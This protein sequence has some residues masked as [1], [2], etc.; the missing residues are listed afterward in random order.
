MNLLGGSHRSRWIVSQTCSVRSS[1]IHRWRWARSFEPEAEDFLYS[2][3]TA[4]NDSR[5]AT[6]R[7]FGI[8]QKVI[9]P[10]NHPLSIWKMPCAY[11]LSLIINTT[12]GNLAVPMRYGLTRCFC[13]VFSANGALQRPRLK[14]PDAGPGDSPRA[15]AD[16]PFSDGTT[17]LVP[18]L[19]SAPKTR[20]E[21][22]RKD[23]WAAGK[24]DWERR[25][26]T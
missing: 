10:W 26:A 3:K 7:T 21:Q 12:T 22:L 19:R 2:L 20:H 14:H 9:R 17:A 23:F 24:P 1:S 8:S 25:H 4:L 6:V 18:S 5:A 13:A 16:E 11:E 15:G